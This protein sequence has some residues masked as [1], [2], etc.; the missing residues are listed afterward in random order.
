MEN[1]EESV[2]LYYQKDKSD[3][4]Y[5]AYLKEANGGYTVNYAYGRRGSTLKTATKTQN[6]VDYDK[7][8]KVYDSLVRSKKAKG[9]TP[10]D[11]GTPYIHTDKESLYTGIHCQLLNEIQ[12]PKAKEFIGENDYFG[13]EKHDGKRLLLSKGESKIT[14]INKK[15]LSCGAPEPVIESAKGMPPNTIIDGEAVNEILYVFDLLKHNGIETGN[16]PYEARLE[17]LEKVVFG[18]SIRVVTT[19]RTTAEKQRLFDELEKEGGEGIVFKK[20]AAHY[21]PG[22]PSSGGD[23]FKYKFYKTASV[24]VS[25]RNDK[26]SV[27]MAIID[28]GQEVFVGNVTIPPNRDIPGVGAIIEVRYLYAYKGGSLYQPTYKGVRDDVDRAECLIN[29]LIYKKEDTPNPK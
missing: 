13:Q 1:F 10:G 23:Q 8:K 19:A 22:A 28:D 20:R 2:T 24:I 25:K 26:R 29:Q 21:Q 17:E 15:G 7:A 3:K 11:T 12:C 6:P 18:D 16:S 14:A 27:A 9:Y 5:Q 4:I